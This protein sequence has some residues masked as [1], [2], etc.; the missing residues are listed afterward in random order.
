MSESE[1]K[2]T[3]KVNQLNSKEIK[4]T[5]QINNTNKTIPLKENIE[6]N[7]NL[8]KKEL[9]QLEIEEKINED[10]QQILNVRNLI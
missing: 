7:F 1:I 3:E 2:Y 6:T 4:E 5:N 10:L 9:E 8:L